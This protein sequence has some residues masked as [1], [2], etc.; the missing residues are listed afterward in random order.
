MI[1]RLGM[2]ANFAAMRYPEPEVW[3]RIVGEEL[4]LR[5]AQYFL[6]LCEPT[7]PDEIRRR[8]VAET[9]HWAREYGVQIPTLF[10]GAIAHRYNLFLHPDEDV[11]LYFVQ[12]YRRMLD[13]A[14]EIGCEAAGSYLGSF[15]LRDWNDVKRREY[16]LSHALDLYRELTHYAQERGFK[17]LMLEP[18]STPR[19]Y[20]ST[21]REAEELYARVNEEA[22][23]PV[24]ACLDVGHGRVRTGE[25]EDADPYAWLRRFGAISPIVHI[26]QTDKLSSKHWPFTLKTNAQGV[27]EAD[28]VLEAL[29]A[30]GATETLL[31]LELDYPAFEPFDDQM[32]DDLHA[33][34]RYWRQYIKD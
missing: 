7:W 11:R 27:I 12:W 22:A 33:S 4:G 9:L 29:Q 3:L 2:N 30:S 5:Y 13:T 25:P 17:Y 31:V 23:I 8:I 1:V 26:Q 34:V 19:E 28:K 6:D 18:M 21:M 16:V 32:L 15:S 14:A 10:S 24:K 20:P